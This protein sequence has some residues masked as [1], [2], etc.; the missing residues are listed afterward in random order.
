LK[1]LVGEFVSAQVVKEATQKEYNQSVWENTVERYAK[2]ED[3]KFFKTVGSIYEFDYYA[4]YTADNIRFLQEISYGSCLSNGGFAY[5]FFTEGCKDEEVVV[6]LKEL[7]P[8]V[9]K[10]FD[11]DSLTILT[12]SAGRI[13]NTLLA[14]QYMCRESKAMSTRFFT[15]AF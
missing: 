13:N 15:K 11:K 4:I 5:G 2:Y 14:R 10:N 9:Y 7:D 3:T 8:V 6:K 1:S 12:N